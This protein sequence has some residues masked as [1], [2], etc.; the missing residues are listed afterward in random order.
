MQRQLSEGQ[1]VILGVVR[2]P[3]FGPLVMF[4]AGGVEAEGLKD[5]AFALAPLSVVEAGKL[6]ERTWAGRR[7]SGFRNIAPAD[8]DAVKDALVR[9][10]WLAC[11]HPEIKDIE[12]NPLRAQDKGAV[13]LDIRLII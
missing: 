12:I 13:A 9:L 4:G 6:M 5:V 3:T 11:E 7:L 10:S 1:D 2:D 8:G